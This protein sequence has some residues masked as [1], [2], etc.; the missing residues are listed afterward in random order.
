MTPLA[1]SAAGVLAL[2]AAMPLVGMSSSGF[3]RPLDPAPISA[4]SSPALVLAQAAAPSPPDPAYAGI[5]TLRL[6]ADVL[7]LPDGAEQACGVDAA[8]MAAAAAAG[9]RNTGIRLIGPARPAGVTDSEWASAP[10]VSIVAMAIHS[11]DSCDVVIQALLIAPVTGARMRATGTEVSD[12]VLTLWTTIQARRSTPE[13]ASGQMQDII[14]SALGEIAEQIT[15]ATAAQK[16]PPAS[17][18]PQRR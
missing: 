18:T 5:R 10:E 16:P 12:G 9:L 3:A 13:G 8:G 17:A 1:R 4:G 2:L 15:R 7:S 14:S 11:R 6:S